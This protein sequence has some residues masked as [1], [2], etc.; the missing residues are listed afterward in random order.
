[1]T[2]A[3]F[4]NVMLP[5]YSMNQAYTIFFLVYM[6]CGLF[7]LLNLVLAIIYSNYTNRVELQIDEYE[8]PRTNFLAQKFKKF[9]KTERGKLTYDECKE[10]L[11]ELLEL[12]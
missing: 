5:A 9:P 8:E 12:S 11:K 1:M 4:P 2:T 7:F 10:L 3:N 6:I